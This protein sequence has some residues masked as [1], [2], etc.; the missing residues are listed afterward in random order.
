MWRDR[1]NQLAE[2]VRG[3]QEVFVALWGFDEFQLASISLCP[4]ADLLLRKNPVG[5]FY[6]AFGLSPLHTHGSC[7][8]F[9]RI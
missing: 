1:S 7:L 9:D 8:Q 4:L 3:H 2:Y 6:S 5:C